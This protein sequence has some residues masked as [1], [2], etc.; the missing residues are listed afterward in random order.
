MISVGKIVHKL[1]MHLIH[2]KMFVI[3]QIWQMFVILQFIWN[4]LFTGRTA[5]AFVNDTH[6]RAKVGHGIYHPMIQLGFESPGAKVQI[7][8]HVDKYLT[9]CSFVT[10]SKHGLGTMSL[11]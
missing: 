6:K 9:S 5:H 11:T 10:A 2:G 3:L 8:L 7:K 4:K 1:E